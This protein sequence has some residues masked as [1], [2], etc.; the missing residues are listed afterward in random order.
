MKVFV[1]L[2]VYW[3]DLDGETT[4]IDA[5]FTSMH[6]AEQHA[7]NMNSGQA[8]SSSHH[9]HEFRVEEHQVEG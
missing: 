9:G 1:V 3:N 8:Y 2:D 5:I 4:T 7:A 6:Y